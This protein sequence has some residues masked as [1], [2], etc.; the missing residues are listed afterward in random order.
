MGDLSKR[1]DGYFTN[2]NASGNVGI[3][4]TA[5]SKTLHVSGTVLTTSWTGINFSSTGNVTPTAPL[6]VSGTVSATRFVGDGSGLTNLSVQGDRI[7]SGTASVVANQDTGVSV[8]APLEVSG[9]IKMVDTSGAPCDAAD[10]WTMTLTHL[11]RD[12]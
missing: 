12:H 1:W 6:E 10:V 8:S 5:P 3:G 4:T 7:T 11:Y 2:M 9:S